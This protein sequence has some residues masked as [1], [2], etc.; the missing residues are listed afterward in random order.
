MKTIWL[1]IDGVL[2]DNGT[3]GQETARPYIEI[4]IEYCCE[5]K[6]RLYLTSSTR[7]VD[8]VRN[9]M[10]HLFPDHSVAG[11][12][13]ID[14][15]PTTF[16]ELVI[17]CNGDLLK[18][19]PGIMVPFYNPNIHNKFANIA[20]VGKLLES[21]KNR[22]VLDKTKTELPK[23]KSKEENVKPEDTSQYGFTI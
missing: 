15:L 13:H 3:F 20:L 14:T 6:V 12:F 9:I 5:T 1:D 11:Y 21:I 10:E 18:K 22:V 16:P 17:S 7:P 2:V 19:Y 4:V 23:I 8:D